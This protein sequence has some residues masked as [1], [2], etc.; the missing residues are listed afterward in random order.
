VKITRIAH[1]AIAAGQL[2]PVKAVFGDLLGLPMLR[3]ARFDSG[4]EMAMYG[5]G[6]MHVEVLHNPATAS[7]PGAFVQE[8]GT[9][10]F[11]LCLEVEDLPGALAELTATGVK[12]HPDSPRKG[13]SGAAVVFLDPATTGGLLIELAQAGSHGNS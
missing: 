2:E 6:D 13:E 12:L 3:T 11:H 1:I 5:I 8:K 10:Y 4:T 9:G 7:L